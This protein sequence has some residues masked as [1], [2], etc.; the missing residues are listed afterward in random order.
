M[1][2]YQISR[3]RIYM[4]LLARIPSA[5][6]TTTR[7]DIDLY[8]KKFESYPPDVEE[9]ASEHGIRLLPLTSK[10]GQAL[11]LMS[12]PEVRGHKHIKRDEADKFFK[13]IGMNAPDSI[14]QFN[15]ATGFKRLNIKRGHYCLQYPFESDTTDID[16]RKGASISG[17][18]DDRVNAVKEWHK[19]YITDVPNEKWQVGHLDPTIGDASEKNLAF[20]PPIQAK[21]RNRFKFDSSFMKMW[22]TAEKEL[23]PKFDH[24]YTEDEQ[25]MIYEALK[26]KLEK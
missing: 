14:Q 21:Y 10:M 3:K 15:K 11:C 1:G 17:S 6:M 4:G 16:K 9:F 12:Q 2:G 19:K 13:N 22:P 26:Q 23:I 25:K 5:K 18:K 20:Q 7:I 24:Y 8:T